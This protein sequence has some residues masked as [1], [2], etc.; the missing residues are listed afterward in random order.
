VN[1]DQL[2]LR[3]NYVHHNG[4]PGL[5]CDS[6]NIHVL[7]ENNRSEDNVGMGIVHEISYDAI[8]RNNI[9]RRN[10]LSFSAWLWGAGILVAASPNVEIYGNTVEGNGNGIGAVQQARG[11]GAYGPHETS[12]LWVHDND[13]TMATGLTGIAQDINDT[14]YFTSRNNRFQRN[15]YVLGTGALYFT[16]MNNGRTESEWKMYSQDVDGTFSR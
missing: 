14:S 2:I 13:V 7:Y 5:W 15:R 3:G 9:V 6:D 16:W 10:G 8:I 4:G 12:N 1:T 11:A